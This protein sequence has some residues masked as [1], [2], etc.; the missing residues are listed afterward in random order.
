MKNKTTPVLFSIKPRYADLIFKR[1]KTA[2]LRRRILSGAEDRDVFVYVSS[3]ARELR[4]GFRVGQ[5]W[6]GTPDEVWNEVC[7]D[8]RVEK[9]DFDI[10][11]ASSK[12][13]Y[14]LKIEDVWEYENSVSLIRLQKSFSQFVIPQSWRYVKPEECKFFCRMKRK[15]NK[16]PMS[17]ERV[18]SL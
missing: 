12:V 13:A 4:G 5:V 8:A 16:Q 2:E 1:L 6:E 17:F 10:Y 9:R 15:E 14:A 7:K 18:A 11:Y 3:P